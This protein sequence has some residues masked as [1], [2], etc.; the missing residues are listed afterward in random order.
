M[1]VPWSWHLF[2]LVII[3]HVEALLVGSCGGA[4]FNCPVVKLSLSVFV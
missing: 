1:E 3:M 4:N 2:S